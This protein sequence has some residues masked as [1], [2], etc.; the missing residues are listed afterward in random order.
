MP[1]ASYGNACWATPTFP[2]SDG[3]LYERCVWLQENIPYCQA[4]GKK[5]LLSIGGGVLTYQLTTADAG[6]AF[7]NQLWQMY[8]PYN[9]TYVALGGIRP[10]DGGYYNDKT[11][12]AYWIDIDGFDFDI[13]LASTDNAV[14][15]IAML[16]QLRKL[17]LT[18]PCKKYLLTGSP[19]CSVPDLA[20]GAMIQA[21]PFD[22][23]W[24]QFYNTKDCSART[25]AGGNSALNNTNGKNVTSG[26]TYDNWV[27]TTAAGASKDAKIYIGLL[28]GPAGSSNHSG[29]FLW[30][31]EATN[32]INTYVG[33][34][35][36]GGV[37]LWEATV[38]DEQFVTSKAGFV[39]YYNFIKSVLKNYAP[40]TTPPISTGSI[41]FSTTTSSTSTSK[42]S[43]T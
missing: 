39:N 2:G 30:P 16:T 41:C 40:T 4:K 27:S 9:A 18:N 13:E 12:P 20:M 38:A 5:I 28:G 25:W 42:T 29:D 1:G 33:D 26:F 21:V 7:A 22:A 19:Q 3:H 14:G 35:R 31:L 17:F 36:F 43:T 10:L 24:V 37:M 8:G 6:T 11:D 32:L 23:L 34:T 15:Y